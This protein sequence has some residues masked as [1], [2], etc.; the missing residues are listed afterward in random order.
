MKG[1]LLLLQDCLAIPT[2]TMGLL[3]D[4]MVLADC[5]EFTDYMKSIDFASK[6]NYTV[7]GYMEYLDTAEA[8]YPTLYRKNKWAKNDSNPDSAFVGDYDEGDGRGGG[9]S[10]Y[11]GQGDRGGRGNCD[12]GNRK[13][14][15][16]CVKIGHLART[17]WTPGGGEESSST[18]DTSNEI[19]PGV[20]GAAIRNPPMGE[21]RERT[22]A[23]G[24][25]VKWCGLC[26]SW[27]GRSIP[28][29]TSSRCI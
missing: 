8:K 26:R 18:N 6:R 1:V 27:G 4:V 21:P 12:G 3:N 14:Y 2:D 28:C 11:G 29:R 19:F 10:I 24:T 25:I 23:D 16:T 17:Y 7:G 5:D 20:N 9:R 15:H 22:L 13:R